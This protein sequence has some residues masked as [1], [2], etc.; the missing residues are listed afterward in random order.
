MNFV[1]FLAAVVLFL[2]GVVWFVF[3]LFS[4]SGWSDFAK[5]YPV[6]RLPVGK[7]FTVTAIFG[8]GPS[9]NRCV[10]VTISSDGLTIGTPLP[11][12]DS[13]FVPWS[14]VRSCSPEKHLLWTFVDVEIPSSSD[15]LILRFP[16]RALADL[17]HH[18]LS[19][20]NEPPPLPQCAEPR[21]LHCREAGMQPLL[22]KPG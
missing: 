6:G 9:Y 18:F 1:S 11:H 3:F 19:T 8:G 15:L 5:A 21:R 12:H 16:H 10:D 17:Q 4:Q 20:R 14:A 13:F 2:V 7:R 22:N